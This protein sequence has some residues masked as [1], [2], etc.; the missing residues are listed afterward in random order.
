VEGRTPVVRL[1]VLGSD[2]WVSVTP[3]TAV[4]NGWVFS[5]SVTPATLGNAVLEIAVTQTAGTAVYAQ[6]PVEIRRRVNA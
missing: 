3:F 4:T 1:G 2:P 5:L 6:L